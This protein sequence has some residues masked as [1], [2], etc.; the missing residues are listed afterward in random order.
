MT[1][2]HK[3]YNKKSKRGI[4]LLGILA[5][6][7]LFTDVNLTI[8]NESHSGNNQNDI[9]EGDRT[10]DK[11]I[12]GI[13]SS[14]AIDPIYVNNNWSDMV[15]T[16]DYIT[17]TGTYYDPYT[18]SNVEIDA[19]GKGF[20]GIYIQ[21]TN[22]YFAIKNST[23]YNAN[24]GASG[25]GIMISQAENGRI[26]NCTIY[27]SYEA[28]FLNFAD[29]IEIV[30]NDIYNQMAEGIVTQ[31]SH[32]A[33][34]ERNNIYDNDVGI[35]ISNSG[36][37]NTIYNNT[38]FNNR[39]HGM[40]IQNSD[41]HNISLNTITNQS[42]NG[43][44]GIHLDWVQDTHIE[45]NNLTDNYY[46]ITI[47]SGAMWS[48]YNTILDN[49]II[50]ST[51][52]G[53]FLNWN[54]NNNTIEGNTLEKNPKG[55]YLNGASYNDILENSIELSSEAIELN[56]NS[57]SN[58]IIDNDISNSNGS[59]GVWVRSNSFSN[60]IDYNRITNI[61]GEGIKIDSS[62]NSNM[63]TYN[64]IT[65]CGTGIWFDNVNSVEAYYNRISNSTG[66]Q[67]MIESS[68]NS[69]IDY[70]T[71]EYG[72]GHGVLI[73][74]SG[75]SQWDF[76]KVRF[77]KISNNSGFG[78]EAAPMSQTLGNEY[79][80]NDFINNNGGT[81]QAANQ[82]NSYNNHFYY[83]A[84]LHGNYYDDH[85]G[86]DNNN[87]GI[88]DNSY[89]LGPFADDYY[90][91]KYPV[92]YFNFSN[93]IVD[94][95]YTSATTGWN[96][97]RFSNI[98]QAITK[99]DSVGWY[100]DWINVYVKN[101]TYQGDLT[102]SR[103]KMTLEGESAE[104]V[105]VNGS[106][107]TDVIDINSNQIIV[108]DLT[109]QNSGSA[110]VLI[111][112]M[113]SNIMIEDC[114]IKGNNRGIEVNNSWNIVIDNNE[115]D[116]NVY[117][118]YVWDNNY[119]TQNITISNNNIS[120]NVQSGI[121]LHGVDN[122]GSV[123][124]VFIENNLIDS[125]SLHGIQIVEAVQIFLIKR[126]NI[127][128]SQFGHGISCVIGGFDQ[129][130]FANITEN[131]IAYNGPFGG[132]GISL[133]NWVQSIAIYMND[134]IDNNGRTDGVSQAQDLNNPI[135]CAWDNAVFGT[136]K[137]RGNYYKGWAGLVDGNNDGIAEGPPFPYPIPG[138]GINFDNYP[139]MNSFIYYD[140]SEIYVDDDYTS[141]TP[142]WGA[143]RFNTTQA[144]INAV[145]PGGKI[146]IANGTYKENLVI[147]NKSVWIYGEDK[148]GVIID[149]N[150]TYSIILTIANASEVYLTE[151]TFNN[152]TQGG[153]LVNNSEY[154]WVEHCIFTY[155]GIGIYVQASNNTRYNNNT[156]INTMGSTAMRTIQFCDQMEIDNNTFYGGL[157]TA[158]TY[159]LHMEGNV[160]VNG[161]GWILQLMS[162]SDVSNY[163]ISPT[164]LANGKP[165]YF[166]ADASGI[167]NAMDGIYDIGQLVLYNVN[168]SV[169]TGGNISDVFI[170]VT[171]YN[172]NNV[173]FSHGYIANVGVGVLAINCEELII[174]NNT[175]TNVYQNGVYLNSTGDTS[176]FDNNI[177]FC[178]MAG[179]YLNNA[180]NNEAWK[181]SISN[182]TMY[183]AYVDTWSDDNAFYLNN[184][185][186][187]TLYGVQVW[188]SENEFALN[189]FFNNGNNQSYDEDY[190][191]NNTW[192]AYQGLGGSYGNYW[193][194]YTARYPSASP[195]NGVWDTPYMLDGASGI[196]NDTYP[197]VWTA[198]YY[199]PRDI[200]VDTNYNSGTPGWQITRF[201]NIQDGI[202]AVSIE[203]W[204][205]GTVHI[206]DGTYYDNLY[207]NRSME[208]VGESLSGTLLYAK[209]ANETTV[210]IEGIN[211]SLT[212]QHMTI[213][214]SSE[215][216]MS[217]MIWPES[218][219]IEN[220][221][222]IYLYDLNVTN[223]IF[224]IMVEGCTNLI[225]EDCFA[226]SWGPDAIGLENCTTVQLLNNTI[227]QGNIRIDEHDGKQVYGFTMESCDIINGSWQLL[228]GQ[229][230]VISNYDVP[231]TN[232]A[233]GKP[234]LYRA[235]LNAL[236]I[237]GEIGE[238]I[239]V[240]VN[241]SLIH[242][243]TYTFNST[244][245]WAYYS[246]FNTYTNN[247]F[248][249]TSIAI[250]L[251]D[252]STNNTI[253]M[254]TFRDSLNS[255][256][257][258]SSYQ[259]YIRVG[260]NYNEISYN[261][262]TNGVNMTGIICDSSYNEIHHNLFEDLEYGIIF[263]DKGSNGE[264]NIVHLN[265]FTDNTNYAIV[266]HT[267]WNDFYR[268]N[269]INNYENNTFDDSKFTN[270]WAKFFPD[271]EGNYY[272]NYETRY[273]TANNNNGIW[274][275]GY[276]VDG[277]FFRSDPFPLVYP[278]GYYDYDN[279]HVDDDFDNTTLGWGK[280]R[281]NTT[282]AGINAANSYG[283]VYIADGTYEGNIY[284]NKPV[285]LIGESLNGV[286]IKANQSGAVITISLTNDVTIDPMTIQH[287]NNTS[288]D[289]G[290]NIENS[291]NIILEDLIV[292]DNYMGI[293][294]VSSDNIEI[295]NCS[296][297]NSSAYM[298][299]LAGISIKWSSNVDIID[300][301]FY[302]QTTLATEDAQFLYISGNNFY[303]T[304][305]WVMF[306][307]TAFENITTYTV[308]DTNFVEGRPLLYRVNSTGLDI[309]GDIGELIL[310]NVNSSTIHDATFMYSPIG[311][312]SFYS[313]LNNFTKNNITMTWFGIS[314]RYS[315]NNSISENNI[316][317]VYVSALG[318]EGDSDDNRVFS[319]IID[320][321][322]SWMADEPA[323]QINGLADDN[324]IFDNI[325][326]N[327]NFTAIEIDDNA[328]Y[329][330]IYQNNITDNGGS[331]V[332]IENTGP[333]QYTKVYH[334]NFI[335]NGNNSYDED[336]SFQN[337][338][339]ST[340]LYEGNYWS[341]YTNVYPSANSSNGIWNIPYEIDG[342]PPIQDQYPL[343]WPFEFYNYDV[344][345]VDDDYNSATPGWD[346]NHFS[347]INDA[348]NKTN[349]GGVIYIADGTYKENIYIDKPI[350][351]TGASLNGV[352]IHA[353]F[354]DTPVIII[355]NTQDVTLDP[356]TVLDTWTGSGGSGAIFV[357]N[358][359]NVVLRDLIIKDSYT[360][361]S[362]M[363]SSQVLID[364]CT[365][366]N[367]TISSINYN[368]CNDSRI[369]DSTFN[370]G[371]VMTQNSLNSTIDGNEFFNTGYVAGFNV[372]Y[373]QTHNIPDTNT[374]N[375]LPLY[376]RV[377]TTGL[378]YDNVDLGQ[379]ILV[380]VHYS[381]V[382]YSRISDTAIAIQLVN[383]HHNNFLFNNFTDDG[384]GMYIVGS[385]NLTI[386]GNYM[387][388]SGYDGSVP[389]LT[390]ISTQNCDNLTIKANVIQN[391]D[392]LEPATQGFGISMSNTNDTSIYGNIIEECSMGLSQDSNS[393]RVTF[394]M[395]DLINNTNYG[396]YTRNY[397]S[398]YYQNNFI[399]NH[400]NQSFDMNSYE[401]E[402]C[403]WYNELIDRGNYWDNYT[404]RYPGGADTGLG[405][406]DTPWEIDNSSD[407]FRLYDQYPL[408]DR[409]DIRPSVKIT[410]PTGDVDT[411]TEPNL[412]VE[413]N[414]DVFA[415]SY[416]WYTINGTST[417]Y[418][419]TDNA[420]IDYGWDAAGDQEWWTLKFYA[421]NTYN[422]IGESGE[423]TIHKDTAAPVIS[424]VNW[425]VVLEWVAVGN[426]EHLIVNCNVTDNFKLR[427][428]NPVQI[429]VVRPNPINTSITGGWVPMTWMGGTWYQFD[430]SPWPEPVMDNYVFY[431]MATDN[432]TNVAN[433]SYNFFH[434]RD[435]TNPTVTDVNGETQCDYG[436]GSIYVNATIDDNHGLVTPNQ[437]VFYRPNNSTIGSY[438]LIG[439]G[440]DVYEYT[441]DASGHSP[442]E[443]YY[444]QIR[445]TDDSNGNINNT[446]VGY[447]SIIDNVNPTVVIASYDDDT[448]YGTGQIVVDANIDDNH[449]L[450]GTNDI[451]F[452]YPNGTLINTYPMVFQ[453]GTLYRYTLVVGTLPPLDGYYFN[454]TVDDP[455][456]NVN[457]TESGIF[458]ITDS[459][460]P[461]FADL[462]YNDPLEWDTDHL[463]IGLNVTDN[464]K[465]NDNNEV[466]IIIY[467]PNGTIIVDWTDMFDGAGDSYT[468]DWDATFLPH[469]IGT[470]YYFNIRATDNVSNTASYGNQFFDIVDT[471]DPQIANITYNA[472]VEWDT[473]Q[474]DVSCNVTDNYGLKDSGPVEIRIY[475]PWGTP[476]IDWSAMSYVSGNNYSYSWP[477][478]SNEINTSYYFVIRATD[479]SSNSITTV[480]QLFDV[481]DNVLP[482]I[483]D[484]THEAV[485]EWNTGTLHVKCNA[486][487]NDDLDAVDPVEIQIY[488]PNGT[489]L[490]PWAPMTAGT[491]DEFTYDWA[492]A[493]YNIS[494][495][496]GNYEFQ[497]RATD[498]SNNVFTTA[499]Q[500]Y[501][502]T[503][504]VNPQISNIT[505]NNP[506]EWSTDNL[507][508]SCDA[509]D[510]Y[511]LS[512]VQISIYYSN[513]TE[514]LAWTAMSYIS[515]N[516]Y[517]YNYDA[518]GDN[519]DTNAYF[520]INI[521]D[522]SI[523]YDTS[524]NVTFDIVDTVIP[525]ISVPVYDGQVEWGT[526]ILNVSC[527][528]IDLYGLRA[529]NPVEIQIYN[530]GGSPILAWTPMNNPSG[531]TYT[532]NW[533]VGTNATGAD[534]YF[535]I[536]AT[537][538][539]NNPATAGNYMFNINDTVLPEVIIH[540]YDT[541]TTYG[542]TITVWVNVTDNE[543][544]TPTVQ[545]R[546]AHPNGTAISTASMQSEGNNQYSYVWNAG[547]NIPDTGYNF[548]ILAQDASGNLNNTVVTLFDITD[549]IDPVISGEGISPNPVPD[550]IDQYS[551]ITA[552]VTDNYKLNTTNAVIV[553]I[554]AANYSL[555]GS[556]VMNRIATSDVFN[557]TYNFLW[558]Y[559]GSGYVLQFNATDLMG[560][561]VLK[562]YTFS[563]VS[564]EPP[565][566]TNEQVAPTTLEYEYNLTVSCNVTD[567]DT[568]M[569]V[570]A[571]VYYPNGTLISFINMSKVS[572]SGY[573]AWWNSSAIPIA[574][575]ANNSYYVVINATDNDLGSSW[576]SD[577]LFDII[578]TPPVIADPKLNTSSLEYA[579]TI[580]ISANVTD[581][582]DRVATVIAYLYYQNGTYI[583][584][585][586][587][588]T[589]YQYI[590][591]GTYSNAS[592]IVQD[593]YYFIIN[594]TD[595]RGYL[596][597]TGQI[598]N[599]TF[600]IVDNTNPVID[601]PIFTSTVEYH[602]GL[603]NV[604]CNVT[605]N[606]KLRVA[607]PVEIKIFYPWGVE[608]I[609]WAPMSYV[610]GNEYSFSRNMTDVDVNTSYYFIIRA[611]D[612]N[613]R[614]SITTIQANGEFDIIDTVNPDIDNINYNNPLEW[615]TD[616]LG[617]TC[618]VTDNHQLNGSNP[619]LLRIFHP[620][621]TI[622]LDW[623]A[624]TKGLVNQYY[625]NWPDA[626]YEINTSYYFVIDANDYSNNNFTTA[627]QLF[628][629][630][631]TVNPVISNLGYNDPLEWG[632]DTLYISI[633]AT[634][635]YG[636][637][638]ANK[639]EI[640][641]YNWTG[642]PLIGW[643]DMTFEGLNNYSY[644]W[645]LAVNGS[646]IH[647]NYYFVIRIWDVS[648]N[649]D[650]TANQFFDIIDTI[651]PTISNIA[652][653]DPIEWGT[654]EI[655]VG[656]N[657]SD[658]YG[659]VGGSPVEIKFYNP[660]G[661][662]LTEWIGMT[663]VGGTGYNYTWNV[664]G[665]AVGSNYYFKIR[666]TDISD[667][668]LE[669]PNQ[670]FDIVDTVDPQV[671]VDTYN[672]PIEWG[673]NDLDIVV[674]ATDNNQLNPVDPV[675]VSIYYPNG[676]FITKIVM[677]F[678]TTHYLA[679][680]SISGYD[681]GIDY[682]FNITVADS[683]DNT[684]TSLTYNFT[685]E[686]T[687]D[688]TALIIIP[689]E[690]ALLTYKT[691][692]LY[693]NVSVSDN[694]LLRTVDPVNVTFYYQNGTL[695]GTYTMTYLTG[696]IYNYNLSAG[697][698]P[699]ENGYKFRITAIDD[700]N[701]VFVS[702]N[703]TFDIV[704]N[705]APNIFV[706]GYDTVGE[707]G[708]GT[709]QVNVT[710]T[711]ND[712]ENP[713]TI[714]IDFRDSGTNP[715]DLN[716][717][718]NPLGGGKYTYTLS[719]A[720]A[721]KYWD[722]VNYYF[723]VKAQ[724][725]TGNANETAAATYQFDVVD[726]TDP[727]LNSVSL[728]NGTTYGEAPLF[729]IAFDEIVKTTPPP[730]GVEFWYQITNMTVNQT[731]QTG[732]YSYTSVQ[733]NQTAFDA[734]ADGS[735]N[736]TF[737][738][739]D[740]EDN[741]NSFYV[742]LYKDTAEP[743]FDFPGGEDPTGQE[744][745]DD[746]A[747]TFKI[748]IDDNVTKITYEIPSI[749]I[750]RDVFPAGAMSSGLKTAGPTEYT[751]QILHGDW[752][753]APYGDVA[754]VI[755]VYDIAGN[756]YSLLFTVKKVEV[757][758]E[759]E[760][761]P[762]DFMI[763]IIII[764]GS[765]AGLGVVGFGIVKKKSGG[766]D[767]TQPQKLKIKAPGA[768]ARPRP[769]TTAVKGKMKD[770]KVVGGKKAK[771]AGAAPEPG[772]QPLTAE[773]QAAVA[774]TE[775]EM[776]IEKKKHI[777]VVHKG[778]I[779]GMMYICPGCDTYY[780][781]KCAQTL[782]AGGEKCWA[783]E[784]DLEIEITKE[785]VAAAEAAEAAEEAA[786]A[787][788]D[789]RGIIA[790]FSRY[791]PEFKKA[792]E[793]EKAFK[794]VAEFKDMEFN[795]VDPEILDYL[796]DLEL[797]L[798]VKREILQ[799]LIGLTP[800]EQ[801][802]FV[803][804]IFFR[805]EE[806]EEDNEDN[807]QID[808]QTDE[809]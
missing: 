713:S 150:G 413:V 230:D 280:T 627:N 535:Q 388:S 686:D 386:A 196:A 272:S 712:Q 341:N 763:I 31:N 718:M 565:V 737:W 236:D 693:V 140:I 516:N 276:Q 383:S 314:L 806:E 407:S 99:I 412:L 678:N 685:I 24:G 765:V 318:I 666:A 222:N 303:Q 734:L 612:D 477:V 321:C 497:I 647:E 268:N 809:Q 515:G 203:E 517:S 259:S 10:D 562:N 549:I 221:S 506:V 233:F 310:V 66:P 382:K 15:E 459:I 92:E 261:N 474:L 617:I 103:M 414:V 551:N 635:N 332:Y 729:D 194:N 751:V 350:T 61:T 9:T 578:K 730:L 432:V 176:V 94:P 786:E 741:M 111:D 480:N 175:I 608:V 629:I 482:E 7:A 165:I 85:V 518:T 200:Y 88:F 330:E 514:L 633:N 317:D 468:Y 587:L 265:N 214:N 458:N 401:S 367:I 792:M 571:S 588:A 91:L 696:S 595:E 157:E 393:W 202:D 395:N 398:T 793:K 374:V 784:A 263:G 728:I 665:N 44:S 475:T 699:I 694:R 286:I 82:D 391:M 327:N 742:T 716:F 614:N 756:N 137:N 454:I 426:I 114:I 577:L 636:L 225:I 721:D 446:E 494:L 396:V 1:I 385:D 311:I 444:Y 770:G 139:L 519:I 231:D 166:I 43:F 60:N 674:T 420:S 600:N 20:Y 411:N 104:G 723:V 556:Q 8:I 41:Y 808:E 777:C 672:T 158:D 702:N 417:K 371:Y 271:N 586:P 134:F 650:T 611:T 492:D 249:G 328:M 178:G 308:P 198:E 22:D 597:S 537:D 698:Y 241:N 640:R 643:T 257:H 796:D 295:N 348:V 656:C 512:E 522:V 313:H 380:N 2:K 69:K 598:S 803:A 599:L 657:A 634:D 97:T 336:W 774:A 787:A 572:A 112:M 621:G 559:T 133:Q 416:Q 532:Y 531:S 123:Q 333:M 491:G 343:V 735:F 563:V 3:K 42:A 95:S 613:D 93:I 768:G 486:T 346:V 573:M 677:T 436:T 258:D 668:E 223:S 790:S 335:D 596:T 12:N 37:D 266:A 804:S 533:S 703:R 402:N 32:Q 285:N 430:A 441:W 616:T 122:T 294:V 170:S 206:A 524:A 736:I 631:D 16:Y 34:I 618:D 269:F 108:S 52:R 49:D 322:T 174:Q 224:G 709:I 389:M 489:I 481:E 252:E 528:V 138:S 773:E 51:Q 606:Y 118:V 680:W 795:L 758:T 601:V 247:T 536:R 487:D 762:M 130:Q 782:K 100:S 262:F 23:I 323:V 340:W 645:N 500:S 188:G 220:S 244:A 450:Q 243:I 362:A 641:L 171:V 365:F 167:N 169:F 544:S 472:T 648:N 284:I 168:D 338:W 361:V 433:D 144:A 748:I 447:F 302:N 77:N 227:P 513:G 554:Y 584:D 352:R 706:T 714:R 560:N 745:T 197:L 72:D 427:D 255:R 288:G 644:T 250:L 548:T 704:D 38:I 210:V 465:L 630:T 226:D 215:F 493:G 552:I 410:N 325:I 546:F 791:S 625:Y 331:G 278:A 195:A 568:V 461:Q 550:S 622:L 727:E 469:D 213:G 277:P 670:Q 172:S 55:I 503:D 707:F 569:N 771:K 642:T 240:N 185:T 81:N 363:S 496:E 76:N 105:I 384:F 521:S 581:D 776:A 687:I 232:T 664:S 360:G 304:G 14:A 540:S 783:C 204:E 766:G 659:L 212:I 671:S 29:D 62:S 53:I 726:T 448:A 316:Y 26:E 547:T 71:I 462:S 767:Y 163:S 186:G 738:F 419:F 379:L 126:N 329:N 177:T 457:D 700:Q 466:Q 193:D 173:N 86:P 84:A 217:L 701:N 464:Y 422:I 354:T 132:Y 609:A 760:A 160:F 219:I 115:F 530:P 228:G 153:I 64:N 245:M 5:L 775:A 83:G 208:I 684:I 541:S 471:V 364:N 445:A 442:G 279:I 452:Y 246:S 495:H 128:N 527:T 293:K 761:P 353:N 143:T 747:P 483:P 438:D 159:A 740:P 797:D 555:L 675:N 216:N 229:Q 676:T 662:N 602:T 192:Y 306:E 119:M 17:G 408:V 802:L 502:I 679:T 275:I 156:F 287:I 732:L 780:C 772:A 300:N 234:L 764:I 591:N 124:I 106:G 437:I 370:S 164:N 805:D 74:R 752:Q 682:K 369:I 78:I 291:N 473:G 68:A 719:L 669:S 337:K 45:D 658:N 376:Y 135:R 129:P 431:I 798:E 425:S 179:I 749:P 582:E 580:L 753:D 690:G 769:P 553:N 251:R 529:I 307:G 180:Q 418:F 117:G 235:N 58:N 375:G 508:V 651:D 575:A 345:Y 142:G 121:Y 509:T 378:S 607:N 545:I 779:K 511:G 619:V 592:L 415:I 697:T 688:P 290:I 146:H 504:T 298:E 673:N 40:F 283:N 692:T 624:M 75:I 453:G 357:D 715:K 145:A 356:F 505:Y 788:E 359:S 152:A 660:V 89:D 435:L 710:I 39:G 757:P 628:D 136:Y 485:I 743:T 683:S 649:N 155:Q 807:E 632:V 315:N 73:Q 440:G 47:E 301:K 711:D 36:D 652:Y 260:A 574:F 542:G 646:D 620:N 120:N 717:L 733:L 184:F 205:I 739:K 725:V 708:T 406:Y 141:A 21:N 127:T 754:F 19:L 187:N 191:N 610:S 604:S 576:S 347:N 603:L 397:N 403:S 267:S 724:D 270:D 654:G 781:T 199:D 248:I 319:N 116:N 70:N 102:L 794:S 344:I 131:I 189:N 534:Y 405:Y 297:Y 28:I 107:T 484:I 151:L 520:R 46:G 490:L 523:N 54:A 50:N 292:K 455:S 434:I 181:N 424:N 57:G 96:V 428:N 296:I 695:I 309:S 373:A 558:H 564:G 358:S 759:P 312:W 460:N 211:Q 161:S 476:L 87:D 399:G 390:G 11:I 282:Q 615:N 30:G 605:D 154:V 394:Y 18:I 449:Q 381:T 339:Y 722:D 789:S 242:D 467:Y 79:Y 507:I 80:F 326:R 59:T 451:S 148:D 162:M 681:V 799:D 65:K 538:I 190:N 561:F 478:G 456:G 355:N 342:A 637:R 101:G 67:V 421:N 626:G 755:R 566:I 778:P 744:F 289:N 56:S 299:Q 488:Y 479:N 590:W 349:P 6:T 334:N 98:I 667:N 525:Q 498:F 470:N 392:T 264:Y 253:T 501:I 579:N 377:N 125:S 499:I 404:T 661:T 526:G 237:T 663:P 256:M 746:S 209:N 463:L 720:D 90:P 35:T 238:L 639:A 801:E 691:G 274:S 149:G 570:T 207:I 557:T 110:G 48:R 510:N 543:D 423:I 653:N 750:S 800:Y 623:T 109:I 689:D 409:L 439:A 785:A 731:S 320:N 594:A 705:E 201:D 368:M 372:Q 638:A 218:M 239:L 305:G 593:N 567:T 429:N 589:T 443:Y 63:L 25:A 4:T 273:P 655:I 324:K 33:L 183:G 583:D 147:N 366:N 254:N 585:V 281:F 539:S 387:D 400:G 182:T 351:L 27:D 113:Q 13:Q